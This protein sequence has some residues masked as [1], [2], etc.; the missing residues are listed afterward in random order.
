[1]GAKLY[2]NPVILGLDLLSIIS[3]KHEAGKFTVSL[4][5][6]SLDIFE[7]PPLKLKFSDKK[8]QERQ[9][10]SQAVKLKVV[11]SIDNKTDAGEIRAI[12]GIIEKKG[13]LWKKVL[14]FVVPVIIIILLFFLWY[15]YLRKRGIK[16]NILNAEPF[17][18]VALKAIDVLIN[19]NKFE[20]GEVKA[21]YFSLSKIVREYMEHLR[22]FPAAEFTTGEIASVIEH[23]ESR[24]DRDVLHLLRTIDLIKFA[25][26]MPDH[27]QKKE[28][29]Q[30]AVGY[31][32]KTQ[33]KDA[34]TN[35]IDREGEKIN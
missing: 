28:H 29:C 21:F 26:M 35:R 8:Q 30:V 24:E 7:V 25:D 19:S 32:K 16:D 23:N 13:F 14:F 9:F 4:L 5:V 34:E 33:P 3:I 31:V 2:E 1:M 20:K 27:I 15:K 17:D 10:K 18:V 12:K 11:S 6:D 22:S